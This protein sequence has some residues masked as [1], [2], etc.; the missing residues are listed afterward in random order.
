MITIKINMTTNQNFYSQ[1]LIVQCKKLKLNMS[2]KAFVVIKKWLILVI[3][4]LIS[5]YHNDSNKLVIIKAKHENGS[6]AIVKL[7]PLK[8]K[9]YFLLVDDNEYKKAKGGE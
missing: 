4:W 5:K 7:V 3:I 2:M 8:P 6:V 1:T 9:M